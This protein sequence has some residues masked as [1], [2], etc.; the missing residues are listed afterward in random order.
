MEPDLY[1]ISK[2]IQDKSR[3][4]NACGHL[5]KFENID[6]TKYIDLKCK[7]GLELSVWTDTY[8]IMLF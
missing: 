1:V 8:R 3:G 2:I 5:R 7:N 6:M 4:H